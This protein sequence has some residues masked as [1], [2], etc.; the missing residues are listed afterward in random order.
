[1]YILLI[2]TIFI[3]FLFIINLLRKSFIY[4]NE[5]VLKASEYKVV[6][7]EEKDSDGN[8][9]TRYYPMEK[10]LFW[11]NL[12]YEEYNDNNYPGICTIS[13]L[14]TSSVESAVRIL[15]TRQEQ[16]SDQ[17]EIRIELQ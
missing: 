12:W 3:I 15:K 10:V 16:I 7:K 14:S 4:P 11:Q 9:E 17:K 1:M 2:I 8:T 6:V 13:C 5:P